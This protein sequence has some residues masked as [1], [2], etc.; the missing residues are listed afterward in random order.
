M[1]LRRPT[2]CR[3]ASDSDRGSIPRPDAGKPKEGD[4]MQKGISQERTFE[5]TG[6][7]PRLRQW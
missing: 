3:W 5:P 1:S 2:R 6:H 4:P 7:E